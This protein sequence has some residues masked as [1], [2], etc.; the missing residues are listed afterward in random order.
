MRPLTL[1]SLTVT[2]SDSTSS[3]RLAVH[4]FPMQMP[5]YWMSAYSNQRW[6]LSTKS[7][8]T[9]RVRAVTNALRVLVPLL[10]LIFNCIMVPP[11][12]AR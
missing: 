11:L 6:I 8:P 9:P 1:P 5:V 7:E 4:N 12:C 3:E 2:R 10:K